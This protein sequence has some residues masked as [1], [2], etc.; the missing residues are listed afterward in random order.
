MHGR[1]L[2]AMALLM[3]AGLLTGCNDASKSQ[4]TMLTEENRELRDQIEERDRA[5]DATTSDLREANR[6][7]REQQELMTVTTAT[8]GNPFEG[9]EGVSTTVEG[10]E[11]T[12]S[13]EG[14]ILFDSGRTSLRKPAKSSLQQIASILNNDYQG[15]TIVIAGHTD[16]D[17]I[18]KSGFKSN[19]HL[20]FERGWAVYEYLTS[21]GV[22]PDRIAVS[23]YGPN[24]PMGTKKESRRVEIVVADAQ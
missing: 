16:S 18:R 21:H 4:V 8:S 10:D 14:D 1:T 15:K 2:T 5:L 20:G 17:P 3:V 13:M 6:L 23:S 7:L 22:S 9:I 19:H 12:V 24:A 11:V